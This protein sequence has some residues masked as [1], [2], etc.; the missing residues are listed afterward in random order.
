MRP[1]HIVEAEYGPA[2]GCGQASYLPHYQDLR[3]TSRSS[4]PRPHKILRAHYSVTIGVSNDEVK[5]KR[6][7]AIE[8]FELGEFGSIH[9]KS[10]HENICIYLLKY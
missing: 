1:A 5:R 9:I 6:T 4:P 10:S 8:K 2:F 3:V 7:K